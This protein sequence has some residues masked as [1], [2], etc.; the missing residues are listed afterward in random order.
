MKMSFGMIFSIILIIIFL[1]FGFYVIKGFF[2]LSNSALA[3]KF[4]TDLQSNVNSIWKGSY[5]AS[6]Q[7]NYTLP[8]SIQYVCFIDLSSGERGQYSSMY[9]DLQ[10]SASS[11][12]DNMIF[13]PRGSLSRAS[14][15]INHLNTTTMATENPYCIKAS[16]GQIS[17]TLMM[18]NG[19]SSVRI[20]R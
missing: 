9:S 2:N 13:Y 18:N 15:M 7:Y 11:T 10:L 16:N 19:E 4:V 17:L 20:T 14:A 6:Q 12:T 3:G 5:E 8:D 1:A